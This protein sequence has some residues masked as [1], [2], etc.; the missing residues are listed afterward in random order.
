MDCPEASGHLSFAERG[1]APAVACV[2]TL[3]DE[4]AAC[5]VVVAC[6]LVCGGQL[7][8][9]L[10]GVASGLVP[11][12]GGPFFLGLSVGFPGILRLLGTREAGQPGIGEPVKA[13][14]P[15]LGGLF[16]L[17]GPRSGAGV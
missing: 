10:G 13:D 7:L 5:G 3:G 16:C 12:T 4:Y 1:E 11:E 15:G 17:C 6:A 14:E 8:V 9:G 2:V